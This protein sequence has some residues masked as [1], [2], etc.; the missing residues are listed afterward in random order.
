M[1]RKNVLAP[2]FCLTLALL[3]GLGLHAQQKD[4]HFSLS[5]RVKSRGEL[6]AGGFKPDTLDNQRLSHFIIG[7]YRLTADYQRSWL[8]LRNSA[9]KVQATSYICCSPTTK[10]TM[11]W[12]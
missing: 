12:T 3:A 2:L 9:M 1:K 7:S 8:E 11:T 10:T 4:N 5:A 6:R